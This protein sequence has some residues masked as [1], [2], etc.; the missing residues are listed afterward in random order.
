[1]LLAG[2][3]RT[4]TAIQGFFASDRALAPAAEFMPV[5]VLVEAILRETGYR[6]LLESEPRVESETRL[7]NIKEFLGVT[8]EYDEKGNERINP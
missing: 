8:R 3:G 7:E 5:T 4:A 1:M 6:L 2:L